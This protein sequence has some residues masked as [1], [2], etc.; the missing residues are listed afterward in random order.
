MTD[1]LTEEGKAEWEEGGEVERIEMSICA[2][3]L[4]GWLAA[5]R[6]TGMRFD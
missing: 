6:Q 1:G 2:R 4:A 5:M 3:S